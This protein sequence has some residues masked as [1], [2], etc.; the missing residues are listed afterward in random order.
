MNEKMNDSISLGHDP[1]NFNIVD[2]KPRIKED[3]FECEN[4]LKRHLLIEVIMKMQRPTP[5]GD[6]VSIN[7]ND[8]SKGIDK[9]RENLLKSMKDWLIR[10]PQTQR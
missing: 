7:L 4:D 2:F 8:N 5:N 3:T 6:F 1:L 10:C 9:I